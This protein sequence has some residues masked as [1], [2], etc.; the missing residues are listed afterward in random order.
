[1]KVARQT[2]WG[3]ANP[4]KAQASR[5]SWLKR[6]PQRARA[7][8]KAWRERNREKVLADSRARGRDRY[9]RLYEATRALIE[10]AKSVPCKDCGHTFD[11][12]CMD[13]DH[14][15]GE[16]KKYGIATMKGRVSLEVVR[17]EIAK[18]DVVCANCH[19]LRTKER[20]TWDRRN[21]NG[22]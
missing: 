21:S 14:R 20:G 19:R 3:R 1:M 8:K 2:R 22:T 17:R 7:L 9:A 10:A 4:A 5:V 18:C 6:N 16:V 15:P 12:V 13:F 11:Q